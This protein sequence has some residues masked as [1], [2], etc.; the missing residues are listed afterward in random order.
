MH[1]G[2]LDSSTIHKITEA[3]KKLTSSD[4]PVQGVPLLR[5]AILL[6][7]YCFRLSVHLHS[8]DEVAI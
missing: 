1:T 8:P 3:E 4:Q 6:V 5:V 2:K 7:T